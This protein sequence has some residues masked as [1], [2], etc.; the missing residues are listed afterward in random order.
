MPAGCNT[1]IQD[2]EKQSMK[3]DGDQK[4][5]SEDED[6]QKGLYLMFS[7][8]GETFGIEIDYVESIV[9]LQEITPVP[10]VPAYIRGVMNLR[11][12]IIPVVDMRLKFKKCPA[13]FNERT[14]VV[15][16]NM[17]EICVGLIVDEVTEVIRV[18]EEDI[19]PPPDVYVSDSHRYIGGIHTAGGTVRMLID[20]ERLFNGDETESLLNV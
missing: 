4:Y 1:D 3:P 11:G 16:M 6:T 17:Q 14:S 20:C 7:L 15:I 8:D 12:K 19:V 5:L 18:P 2:K 10:E 9:A 13:D